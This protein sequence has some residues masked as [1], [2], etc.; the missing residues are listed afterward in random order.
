MWGI[1][2]VKEDEAAKRGESG[3][4]PG[5]MLRRLQPRGNGQPQRGENQEDSSGGNGG[6]EGL[7]E[8]SCSDPAES[9]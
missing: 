1:Q 2:R 4:G 7:A 8:D 9:H 6:K 5:A 3:W